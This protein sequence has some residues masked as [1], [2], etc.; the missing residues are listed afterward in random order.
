MSNTFHFISL[1]LKLH[2]GTFEQMTMIEKKS[3]ETYEEIEEV[4]I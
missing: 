2:Q 4:L 1:F 3:K